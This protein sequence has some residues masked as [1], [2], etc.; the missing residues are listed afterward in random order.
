MA[1]KD[2][3]GTTDKALGKT[4]LSVKEGIV[5][6]LKGIN[7]IEAE[8]VTLVRNTDSNDSA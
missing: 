6:S 5:S 4:G 2:T 7:E 1:K 8:I 3:I